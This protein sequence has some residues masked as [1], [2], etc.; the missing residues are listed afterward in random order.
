VIP[1]ERGDILAALHRSGEVLEQRD[2]DG[3]IYVRARLEDA[4]RRSFA[5]WMVRAPLAV[6]PESE[7]V[8]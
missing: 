2:E 1:Y 7:V 6:G 5:Q 3:A 8:R 4:S